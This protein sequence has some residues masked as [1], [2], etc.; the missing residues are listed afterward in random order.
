MQWDFWDDYI[1][2]WFIKK[3]F[4]LLF[5]QLLFVVFHMIMKLYFF[6]E[7]EKIKNSLKGKS[8]NKSSFSKILEIYFYEFNLIPIKK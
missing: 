7:E 5:F 2:L 8:K 4:I 3:I 1:L 6:I